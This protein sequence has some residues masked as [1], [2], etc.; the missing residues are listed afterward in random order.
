MTNYENHYK[1]CYIKLENHILIIGNSLIERT[2]D[3]QEDIP[4]V[5]SLTH[6]K[7]KK[8]W[9]CVTDNQD[10]LENPQK[11]YAFY[12]K[13]ITDMI[14]AGERKELLVRA[15]TDDDCGIAQKHMRISVTL[16]YQRF[17]VEWIH[18]IYPETPVLRS[19]LRVTKKKDAA[20][21]T[22]QADPKGLLFYS[23]ELEDD[24]YDSFPIMPKHCEWDSVKF[25]DY[26]DDNDNLVEPIHGI[27]TR[28]ENR[29]MYGNLLLLKDILSEEGI[30]FIKEGPT[31]HSYMGD[32][33]SD[34]YIHGQNIFTTGWGL[35]EKDFEHTDTVSGY[36]GAVIV[37]DGEA[38]NQFFSLQSYHR[39]RHNFVP[40]KD[41]F[42]M[43]NTWGDQSS[44]GKISEKFLLDELSKAKEIG[45]N[46]Y[47]I[48]DGWQNGTTCNSVNASNPE[49]NDA[50]WG[51]GYYKANPRFWT[52]HDTRLPNGLEP[53]VKYAKENGI[54][55]GLWFSPDSNNEF[56]N[57]ERDSSVLL[58]LHRKYGITAFKLDGVLLKSKVSE[59][60]LVKL[61]Q[62]VLTESDG[63]IVFNMDVTA[64]TRSGYFGSIHYGSLFV[65]NRFTG[66]FG[67][68]PNYY[69]HRTL[70]NL[71]KLSMYYPSNRLQ[72]EFVNVKR[73][74]EL[75]AGD[76]LSPA[77]CG[78]EY[79]FAVTM[80]A[81]PLGWMELT[82]LDQES[83]NL[84]SGIIPAYQKIQGDILAGQVLPIGEEPNGTK[85]TG[86]QSVKTE[87]EGYLLLLKEYNDQKKH[88]YTLWKEKG[89]ELILKPLFGY[90]K[91]ELVKVNEQGQAVFELDDMFTYAVY[92]Y[93]TK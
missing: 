65:E 18:F 61:L 88:T 85:W 25:M 24:Y 36:G 76:V 11:K 71:W 62:K 28:R 64:D 7:T 5:C 30:T 3:V 38:E 39:A 6:K 29:Y 70:R 20:I 37:W 47:Q 34:F 32:T 86:F 14:T 54:R 43:S 40:E 78:L 77:S 42:L 59:D 74:T 31:P 33:R 15:N 89:K 35:T 9:L 44:D 4:T 55:I 21:K 90:G 46:L 50:V 27:M 92:K 72:M 26:T 80:F 1:D 75:Y 87:G 17:Y 19:M 10:W 41:V 2:W 23:K 79:T 48:D 58:D 8:Q 22:E 66:N 68:Y 51:E 73:N 63:K 93:C 81:N 69:P 49:F 57:W 16:E 56:E 82:G 52:V 91:Q 12:K 60:N 53:I 45:I 84:L 83:A 67:P 13:G